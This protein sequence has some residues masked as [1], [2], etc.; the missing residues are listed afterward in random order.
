M[1]QIEVAMS[2]LVDYR[3]YASVAEYAWLAQPVSLVSHLILAL[4]FTVWVLWTWRKTLK[5]E[6]Y[7]TIAIEEKQNRLR[8]I[9]GE[10]KILSAELARV[11]QLLAQKS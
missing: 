5:L 9:Q 3:A 8:W 4:Y 10:I 1:A 7:L 11:N 2:N 6:H